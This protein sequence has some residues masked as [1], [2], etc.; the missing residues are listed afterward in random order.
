MEDIKKIVEGYSKEAILSIETIPQSGG[1]R[2]YFR[3]KTATG[4]FIATRNDNVKE[5]TAF[6]YFSQHFKNAFCPVPEI[7]AVN[8]DKTL[9]LQQDVGDT[10]LLNILETEGHTDHVFSLFQKSLLAL[11][12]LQVSGDK[13]LDYEHC[14]TSTA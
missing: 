13:G 8:Q 11:A 6:I 3:I 1:D 9:Y 12:N 10:S 14:I 2:V 5:N 4:S 7:L